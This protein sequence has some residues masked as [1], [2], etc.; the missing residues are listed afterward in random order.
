MHVRMDYAET[1]S[2]NRVHWLYSI[3]RSNVSPAAVK[4]GLLFATFMI[5]EDREEVSPSYDW[6]MEQAKLSRATVARCLME[7]EEKGYLETVKFKGHRTAYALPFTGDAVW[8]PKPKGS[9]KIERPS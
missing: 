5:A 3:A 9:S 2:R 8:E 1:Y 6:I 4:L 7:L